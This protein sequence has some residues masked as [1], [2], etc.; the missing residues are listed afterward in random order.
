MTGQVSNIESII[1]K[2]K[3]RVSHLI[4]YYEKKYEPGTALA[5]AQS[6]AGIETMN[7]VADL[8][9]RGGL[10]T[11]EKVGDFM[12]QKLKE[13]EKATPEEDF[14]DFREIVPSINYAIQ[15][16]GSS[17]PSLVEEKLQALYERENADLSIT[18]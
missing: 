7:V 12:L 1:A 18:L 2:T 13:A 4:P 11:E 5:W 14:S 6:I 9:V 16:L 3:S 15:H 8:L 17:F 10:T